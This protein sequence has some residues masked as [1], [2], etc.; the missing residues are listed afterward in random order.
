[1]GWISAVLSNNTTQ[2]NTRATLKIYVCI[3]WLLYGWMK[4]KLIFAENQSVC[5]NVLKVNKSRQY[6]C[7]IKALDIISNPIKTECEYQQH[8]HS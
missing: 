7:L 2:Q 1:M 5:W 6:I 4:A 3:V 8:I